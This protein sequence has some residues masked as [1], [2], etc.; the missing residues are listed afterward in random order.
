MVSERFL[1]QAILGEPGLRLEV[2]GLA[3]SL[4]L[5]IVFVKAVSLLNQVSSDSVRC[6]V[7]TRCTLAAVP[8]LTPGRMRTKL[9]GLPNRGF[10]VLMIS[11]LP[12]FLFPPNRPCTFFQLVCLRIAVRLA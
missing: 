12:L 3:D 2:Q 8:T 11:G 1:R 9:T 10:S 4:E 6:L 5:A 7:G